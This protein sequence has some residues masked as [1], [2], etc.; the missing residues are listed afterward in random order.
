[1]PVRLF[2]LSL[3]LFSGCSFGGNPGAMP[4][5]A[6]TAKPMAHHPIRELDV[7]SYAVR[8]QIPSL[9]SPVLRS[10]VS[11]A[12]RAVEAL[13]RVRLDLAADSVSVARVTLDGKAVEFSVAEGHGKA[14]GV[15]PRGDLLLVELPEAVS[16]GEEFTLALETEVRV[17]T[18]VDPEQMRGFN[19]VAG[20]AGSGQVLLTRAWPYYA[21]YWLPG[22]D[23]PSDPA[24]FSVEADVPAQYTLLSNG[25]KLSDQVEG[26]RRV[27]T[28]HLDAPTPT[29]NFNVVMGEFAEHSVPTCASPLADYP[30]SDTLAD[31]STTAYLPASFRANTRE[32]YLKE[33]AKTGRALAFYSKFLEPFRFGKN[34]FVVT[35]FP[36]AMEHTSLVTLP[37]PGAGVHELAHHWWGNGATI[38]T[39][40]DFWISEGFTTYLEGYFFE[41]S[42]G[43]NT[44]CYPAGGEGVL[45][46]EPEPDP[47]ENFTMVAYCRGALAV[48]RYREMLAQGLPLSS[49]ME[50]ARFERAMER[51]YGAFAG[52]AVS[53]RALLAT[54]EEVLLAEAAAEGKGALSARISAWR[55]EFFSGI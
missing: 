55:E 38:A 40:S 50:R 27:V 22:N 15:A 47:M 37:G 39:W 23:H 49:A 12:I 53:T 24:R 30:C 43:Q 17:H 2:L 9:D 5:E 1:M 10:D 21:R 4:L 26:E 19:R 29:Y 45:V 7:Q 54:M 35:R 25:R 20:F 11:I 34:A 33:L 36:F 16:A 3:I 6:E 52:R 28:W 41:V 48:H 13:R 44:A 31:V 46:P 8:L 42:Q 51:I 14:D 18:V 32:P